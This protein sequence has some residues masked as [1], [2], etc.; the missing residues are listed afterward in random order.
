MPRRG[1]PT[2]PVRP[3]Q[4]RRPPAIDRSPTRNRALRC[5]ARHEARRESGTQP[6]ARRA[7]VQA[8][9]L[10]VRLCAKWVPAGRNGPL[11]LRRA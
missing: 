8:R 4:E 1:A 3:M 2:R 7:G 10:R 5:G 6:L 9:G 11:Q